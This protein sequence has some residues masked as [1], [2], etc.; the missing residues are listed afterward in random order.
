[1]EAGR[2]PA[3]LGT[4][5]RLGR[6]ITL[7]YACARETS[8]LGGS[9]REFGLEPAV[10]LVKTR[11]RSKS[12][13]MSGTRRAREERRKEHRRADREKARE[14]RA[15]EPVVGAGKEEEIDLD[16]PVAEW[17]DVHGD[18]DTE[19]VL[20]ETPVT[21]SSSF[22]LGDLSVV[23]D[24]EDDEKLLRHGRGDGKR[25]LPM[26]KGASDAMAV[27]GGV[28]VVHSARDMELMDAAYV[29]CG[30]SGRC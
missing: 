11:P 10:E 5:R 12:K 6:R 21:P 4:V 8:V 27:D 25:H 3:P 7:E 15:G 28:A 18:T 26:Q 2:R 1:M 13:S 29:L 22:G 20:S 14:E 19:G 24:V 23:D 16:V 30:L 17:D 9:R